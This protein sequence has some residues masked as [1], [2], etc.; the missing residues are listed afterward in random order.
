MIPTISFPPPK[1]KKLQ[2]ENFYHSKNTLALNNTRAVNIF[3]MCAISI[4]M[5]INSRK[6][7]SISIVGKKNNEE[8]LLSIAEKIES[9]II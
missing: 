8:E 7:L 2:N 5:Y 9:I 1:L 3:N 4:P 6:W